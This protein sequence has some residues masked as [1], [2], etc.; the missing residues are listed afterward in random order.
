MRVAIS[1]KAAYVI[2]ASGTLRPPHEKLQ[3]PFV[4]ETLPYIGAMEVAVCVDIRKWTV[5]E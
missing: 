2:S 4:S 5:W 3:W 1:M